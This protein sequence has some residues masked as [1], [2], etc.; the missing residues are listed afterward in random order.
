[1]D[2]AGIFISFRYL[3]KKGPIG[4]RLKIF[5]GPVPGGARKMLSRRG[6]GILLHITSLPSPHGIGDLGPGSY[7]FAD[8][9]ASSRQSHWQVLPLTPTEKVRGE[10][11]YNSPSAFAGNPLLI[12]PEILIQDGYLPKTVL[13]RRP[14]FPEGKVDY[15][16]VRKYKESLLLESYRNFPRGEKDH[17]RFEEFSEENRFWIEDYSLFMACKAFFRGRVWSSWPRGVRDREP[18]TIRSLTAQFK[19]LLERE[20]FF[21]YLFFRQWV[22]L[23]GYCR[24]KG[25]QIIGDLPIYVNYDSADVWSNPSI[26]QIDK[27]KRPL[28]VSGIPPDYFSASGQL[29]GNPLYRWELLK[30]TGYSW[31]VRRVGQ[32]LKLFDLIRLD[33]FK[34]FVDYWAV[35]AR[36]KTAAKGKWIQGPRKD[37]FLA[38]L[39]HYPHL[40]FIAED[41]GVIT[42]EV[43]ELRDRFEFP[44]MRVLQFAFGNDPL[45]E[46]Y[47]PY[48]FIRNCV[49]YPGTH[50]N[51]TLRGWLYGRQDYSTRKAGEVLLEKRNIRRFL[52]PGMKKTEVPWEIIRMLMA[53]VAHLVIVPLQD[54]V[55]AGAEG[56][57]NR[58]GI[59]G[60]NWVWRVGIKKLTPALAG[61]IGRMTETYGRC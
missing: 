8:F 57:M 51:D 37:F 42:A 12:S 48:S 23:K 33:H 61:R 28:A 4:D 14:R 5:P 29:W 34:G 59:A 36:H 11:P 26:F 38:L 40:P 17:L 54:F 9:L 55:G 50:D 49:A 41:L 7:R 30:K 21:Q 20:K 45:A 16:L 56:R 60:G 1:M 47:K 24:E 19:P 31:W 10:S 6:S 53:S 52:G 39:K 2:F 58:P 13:S 22:S 46:A 44:G 32:N 27:E 15:S 35:P 25:I 43:H 3:L 18:R